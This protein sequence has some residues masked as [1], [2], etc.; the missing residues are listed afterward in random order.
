[1]LPDQPATPEA[2]HTAAPAAV[3]LKEMLSPGATK[4]LFAIN[5]GT[6]LIFTSTLAMSELIPSVQIR[7]NILFEVILFN[8]I[9]PFVFELDPTEK[10]GL[11]Q[12]VASCEVHESTDDPPESTRAGVAI[13]EVI[14]G[15]VGV[16]GVEV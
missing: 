2:V 9:E 5:I 7:L 13:K 1:M 3:Q 12:E 8:V 11:L 15:T 6:T 4:V 10:S 14:F 16:G